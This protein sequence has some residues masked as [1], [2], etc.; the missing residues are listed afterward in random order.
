MD[1]ALVL[2]CR[3]RRRWRQTV[4]I[5]TVTAAIVIGTDTT[6]IA[7]IWFSL[8]LHFSVLDCAAVR[9]CMRSEWDSKLLHARIN[10]IRTFTY[11]RI[12]AYTQPNA[13]SLIQTRESY[14]FFLG[15]PFQ[16]HSLLARLL[17]LAHSFS[18][19]RCPLCLFPL[20]FLHRLFVSMYVV[21]V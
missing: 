20:Y 2:W 4:R 12:H 7:R 15:Y 14:H 21:C 10:N 11:T 6:D 5:E 19:A 3:Q 13:R 17:F 9:Y 8:L 18:P 16:L 1:G